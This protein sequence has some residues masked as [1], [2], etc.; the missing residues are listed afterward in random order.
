MV[1]TSDQKQ[2]I[3]DHHTIF[4]QVSNDVVQ[5]TNILFFIYAQWK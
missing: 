5:L 3:R 4:L 1:Q 2:S